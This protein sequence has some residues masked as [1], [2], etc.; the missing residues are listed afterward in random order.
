MRYHDEEEAARLNAEPWMLD[1]LKHNPNYMGWGPHEDYM[2][3][4]GDGWDSRQIFQT[5]NDFGPWQLDDLNECVNFYFSVNRK[6]EDCDTCSGSGTHPHSQWVSESFY[7]HSSPFK[8]QTP[9]ELQAEA[10][11]RGFGGE[12]KRAL[13]F[14]GYPSDDLLKIYG[15]A[16]QEFCERMQ[17]RGHWNDDITEDEA[18][19]LIAANRAKQGE[20]AASINAQNAPGSRGMG[21]DAINRWILIE[22]RCERLGLPAKCPVCDGH[23]HVYTEDVAHVS[24]TLWWLHPRKGCSRGLEIERIEHSEIPAVFA[25]LREAAKRNADRFSRLPKADETKVAA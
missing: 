10:V 22:R 16:F 8:L 5:W 20:T 18:Q 23:G 3:K 2:R 19:A 21:H 15:P 12:P 4:S 6:S 11:M 14:G 17:K 25:F 7:R 1:L 13:G 9:G 24:L